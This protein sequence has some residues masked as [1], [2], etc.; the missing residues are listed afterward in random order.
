MDPRRLKKKL[1]IK[2][3]CC[4]HE[5]THCGFLLSLPWKV[6]GSVKKEGEESRGGSWHAANA[7]RHLENTCNEAGRNS[8]KEKTLEKVEKRSSMR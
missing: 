3:D 5:H 8:I 6:K 4:A 1:K 7:G 2:H